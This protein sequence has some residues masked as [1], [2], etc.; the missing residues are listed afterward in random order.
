MLVGA[1]FVRLGGFARRDWMLVLA[2][3]TGALALV[4]LLQRLAALRGGAGVA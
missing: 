1:L 4:L 2:G 3:A